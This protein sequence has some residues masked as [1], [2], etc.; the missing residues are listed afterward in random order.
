MF[1]IA[2]NKKTDKISL[3]NINE[4]VIIIVCIYV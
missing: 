2:N 4:Y 1:N 3:T